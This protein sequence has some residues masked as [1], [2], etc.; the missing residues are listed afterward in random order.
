MY[1]PGLSI[2]AAVLKSKP[3]ALAQSAGTIAPSSPVITTSWLIDSSPTSSSSPKVS[4]IGMRPA[5]T[6]EPTSG[7][8]ISSSLWAEAD[9]APPSRAATAR[10]KAAEILKIRFMRFSLV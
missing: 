6:V 4:V 1:S 3:S 2:A 9:T 7:V 10:L 8:V 5:S